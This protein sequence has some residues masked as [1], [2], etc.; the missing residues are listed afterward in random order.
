MS[1]IQPNNLVLNISVLLQIIRVW[2]LGGS[3][4][5]F[6]ITQIVPA[7][8]GAAGEDEKI[9]KPQ[10]AANKRGGVFPDGKGS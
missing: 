7:G 10:L 4:F 5:H 3:W 9:E 1:W 8:C 2:L 6:D